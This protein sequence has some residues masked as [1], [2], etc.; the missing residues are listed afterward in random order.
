MLIVG[1]GQM[2]QTIHHNIEKLSALLKQLVL[3]SSFKSSYISSNKLQPLIHTSV[4]KKM[5]HFPSLVKK[6]AERIQKE[7]ANI[8]EKDWREV[9]AE[10]HTLFLTVSTQPVSLHRITQLNQKIKQ[11]CELSETQAESDSYIQIENAST[12][13]L[14]ASGNI[15]VLGSGCIN[16]TIHSGVRVKIKRTLRGGEVYAILGADIHRAGSDSGTATFIEVPEGQIICIKTAMKGT[17][18]KVGSKT[19]TFNETTRQVTAALDTSGHLMLE[20]VGS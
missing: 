16:T 1:L 6:Y 19:H 9:G 10:L 20:E 12:G 18:I 2:L 4:K 14:Y 11:L 15:F 17:T 5:K 8:K 7:E 13:R 3:S